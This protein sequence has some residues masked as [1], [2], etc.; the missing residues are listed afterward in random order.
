MNSLFHLDLLAF[1]GGVW[2]WHMLAFVGVWTVLL[3]VVQANTL[4]SP[5]EVDRRF[6]RWAPRFRLLIDISFI[7]AVAM[8]LPARGL[9]AASV[10]V[11]VA[12]V[13]RWPIIN[14]SAARCRC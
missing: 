1:P 5:Q 11:F 10:L 8:F 13:A 7:T 9:V 14:T 3:F 4:R 12:H 6:A 2:L